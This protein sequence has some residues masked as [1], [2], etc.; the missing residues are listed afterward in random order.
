MHTM[1]QMAWCGPNG[2]LSLRAG[3]CP[4]NVPIGLGWA[5]SGGQLDAVLLVFLARFEQAAV[6][7]ERSDL[8]LTSTPVQ[9]TLCSSAVA[10]DSRESVRGVVAVVLRFDLDVFLLPPYPAFGNDCA[11]ALPYSWCP[12]R[13]S[14]QE[15][16]CWKK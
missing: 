5:G 7:E 13:N 6:L 10:T 2:R 9:T 11:D 15:L 3:F 4:Y 16:L 8:A 12:V 14:I 1:G